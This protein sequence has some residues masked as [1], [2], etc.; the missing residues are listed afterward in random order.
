MIKKLG[1]SKDKKIKISEG[2]EIDLDKGE[3]SFFGIRGVMIDPISS[4]KRIDKMLGSGGEVIIHNMWF[5]QGFTVFTEM[6]KNNPEQT[7]ERLLEKITKAHSAAGWGKLSFVIIRRDPPLVK[8]TAKNPP[9]EEL[10]GSAKRLVSSF[11]EGVFSKYFERS[12]SSENFKYNV[13]K[14]E[15]EFV[16]SG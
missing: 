1:L 7:R 8:V 12:V 4:S 6:I 13:E 5:E 2:I 3:I 9:F 15:F 10:K 14:S 11:W 16:L